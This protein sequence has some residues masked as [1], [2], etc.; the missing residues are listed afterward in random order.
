MGNWT[1]L[2]V[3]FPLIE[4]SCG[5]DNISTNNPPQGNYSGFQVSQSWPP[6]CCHSRFSPPAPAHQDF[7]V[8]LPSKGMIPSSLCH[9]QQLICG[10]A[11][12]ASLATFLKMQWALITQMDYY[13]YYYYYYL[14]S[15]P[16]V[17]EVLKCLK[18]RNCP[19]V[20][21]TFL[22]K[23][24]FELGHNGWERVQQAPKLGNSILAGRNSI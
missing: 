3:Y 17:M 6:G 11:F 2:L 22:E 7:S 16:I 1:A 10:K 18:L 4:R 24:R 13:Y 21:K 12:E 20:G 23:A 19:G 15:I 14:E 5:V 9:S 8:S